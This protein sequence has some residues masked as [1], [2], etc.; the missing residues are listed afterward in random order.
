MIE[1]GW[2]T[3]WLA[4]VHHDKDIAPAPGP[5]RNDRLIQWDILQNKYVGRP[6]LIMSSRNCAGDFRRISR[7]TWQKFKDFYPGS[8]PSITIEFYSTMLTAEETNIGQHFQI[9]DPPPA[10]VVTV[11]KTLKKKAIKAAK[12]EEAER[13]AA[14][15]AAKIKAELAKTPPAHV[16]QQD[17][18]QESKASQS[19]ASERDRGFSMGSSFSTVSGTG[20]RN[21]PKVVSNLPNQPRNAM[22]EQ[23]AL[24][25]VEAAQ[26]DANRASER[27]SFA[28]ESRA[29]RHNQSFSG[30]Q[31]LPPQMQPP[32][33]ASMSA[34]GSDKVNFP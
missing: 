13:A 10:P 31:G 1:T 3:A 28:S 9:L 17:D 15:A 27:A 23:F 2:L 11:S 12:A 25:A 19:D 22:A 29:A 21:E 34:M 26:G 32:R 14:E 30:V 16:Y 18:E 7:E 5:C 33:T 6:G 8:G 4:Y 20:V 24:R